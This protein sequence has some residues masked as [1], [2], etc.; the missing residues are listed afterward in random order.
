M[1]NLKKLKIALLTSSFLP[2]IGGAQVGIHNIAIQLKKKGHIPIV[3]CPNRDKKALDKLKWRFNY[4]IVGFPSIAY[5]GIRYFPNTVFKI[6]NFIFDNLQSKYKFDFWHVTMAYPLGIIITK[7]AEKKKIKYLIR[8]AGEDI[9][10]SKKIN[11]GYRLD[12]KINYLIKKWL[13]RSRC[14]IAISKTVYSEYKKIGIRNENI[15]YIPNGVDIERFSES[16]YVEKKIRK[17]YNIDKETFIFLSVGRNHPKKNFDFLIKAAKIIKSKN[18]KKFVIIIVGQGVSNMQ[19]KINNLK[20]QKN[21]ILLNEISSGK[22][23]NKPNIPSND[24]ISLY[25]LSNTFAFPSLMET[26]GIVLVEAMAAGLPIIS[27]DAPGCRDVVRSGKDG[28]LIKKFN[29]IEFAK[30]MEKIMNSKKLQNK[31]SKASLKR[32]R[33]FSW[34]NVVNQYIDLY[35]KELKIN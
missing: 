11:Y 15:H 7:Y 13:K 2:S 5:Y 27:L 29:P 9:Q 17:K 28:I 1:P 12:A 22:N 19:K 26:F 24:L 4:E 8:C 33:Y 6:F 25:K 30:A 35:S 18:E 34:S 3:V 31:Y 14:M 23:I 16:P 10:A 20:L 21:F 32:A